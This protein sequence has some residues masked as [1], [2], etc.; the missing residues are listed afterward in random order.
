MQLDLI[1][2]TK[3]KRNGPLLRIV[4]IRWPNALNTITVDLTHV[5][6]SAEMDHNSHQPSHVPLRDQHSRAH[7]CP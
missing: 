2:L 7:S 3:T 4:R 5:G 1:I 6:V